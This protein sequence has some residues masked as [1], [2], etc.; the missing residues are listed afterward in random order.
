GFRCIPASAVAVVL[1]VG[2]CTSGEIDQAAPSDS[3]ADTTSTVT[4]DGTGTTTTT[5]DPTTTAAP[6]TT[7]PPTTTTTVEIGT[8]ESPLP[9]GDP[10]V[11]GFTYSDFGTE[12][13]GFVH[14][15]VET[16]PGRFNDE[17]GRCLV[18]LGTLTP[19]SI[20]DG[21]V[22]NPFATPNVSLIAG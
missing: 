20:D 10:G 1:V 16:G 4:V 11:S 6:T 8:L 19:I 21:S 17:T 12:W 13:E 22:T 7:T 2:A 18:L 5:N 9:V 15:M 3:A 14:G